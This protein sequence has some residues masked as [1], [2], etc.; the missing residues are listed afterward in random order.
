MNWRLPRCVL[1][2]AQDFARNDSKEY[3]ELLRRFVDKMPI[4]KRFNKVFGIEDT[5]EEERKRFVNRIKQSIFDI[6]DRE[7]SDRFGYNKLFKHICFELGVDANVFPWVK[8]GDTWLD[9]YAPPKI[10][11]LTK[12]NFDETLVVLCFLYQH[13]EKGGRSQ[14]TKQ[15]QD[16]LSRTTCDIGIRWKGGFFYP[17]GAKELDESLVEELLGW[18][19]KYPNEN[20]DYS[21]ALNC[22]TKGNFADVIKNCYSAVEGISRKI[23]GNKKTLDNNK[24]ELLRIIGLSKGWNAILNS[25]INYAHDYRHASEERHESTKEETEAYLYMSGLIMRLIIEAK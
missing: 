10:S 3:K 14:L 8:T 11:V 16:I 25:F 12:N 20:R 18:L 23:L 4:R 5:V 9:E 24:T 13:F 6:I 15:I 1:R 7:D 2:Q 19:D 17:S 21:N 22:Y